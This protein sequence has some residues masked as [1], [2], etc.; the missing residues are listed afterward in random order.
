MIYTIHE[1]GE[2][3]AEQGRVRAVRVDEDSCDLVSDLESGGAG[4]CHLAFN[5]ELGVIVC[6]NYKEGSVGFLTVSDDG[7]LGEKRAEFQHEGSSVN[8]KRQTRPHAHGAAFAPGGNVAFVCDLGTDTIARYR[9]VGEPGL[10]SSIEQMDP[11]RTVAGGGPR[12]ILFHPSGRVA[13]VILE[14]GNAITA[15]RVDPDHASLTPLQTVSTLPEHA[16]ANATAAEIQMNKAGTML[17]ASNRGDDTIACFSVD[18]Q[19]GE[20]KLHK[21]VSTGGE[22]PRHF[23]LDPEEK[24][25]LVANQHSDAVRV[26]RLEQGIPVDTGHDLPVDSAA[27]VCFLQ[28]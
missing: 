14:M 16:A 18:S 6:S 22:H 19:T 23:A 5:P 10:P 15:F 21:Q 9:V 27:C 4:P 11:I 7:S 12:H 8:P 13:Y 3:G 25:V 26:F 1:F 24:F 20:L 17:Y 2:I 28:G